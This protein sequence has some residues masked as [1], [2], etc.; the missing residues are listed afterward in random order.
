MG[1]TWEFPC[2]ID[3]IVKIVL[4]SIVEKFKSLLGHEDITK[5]HGR[6]CHDLPDVII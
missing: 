6:G 4:I 1:G 3:F 5:F 2:I